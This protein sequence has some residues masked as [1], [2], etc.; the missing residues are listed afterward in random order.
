MPR[1]SVLPEHVASQIAAGEVVER[2]ASVVKELVEN[3][4]DAGATRMVIDVSEGCRRIRL[5]DNGCGMEADDATLAFQRHAT[6]KLSS[7]DD[8]WNL[9]TLGFRGEAL[10]SIAAV[11]QLTCYTRPANQEFGTK[12][13]C[14]DGTITV[15]ETGCAQ[16][17]IIEVDD[18][19]YNV[20]ARLKFLKKPATEF[21]YIYE[22]VQSLA[23]TYPSI[24]FQ[25]T[26]DGKTRL[27]TSGSGNFNT[28]LRESAFFLGEYT[29]DENNL[30]PLEARDGVQGME[31]T[32]RLASAIS[33]RG[34]R[35]GILTIVNGRPV[36]CGLT[37]KALDNAY[38]DL[39]PRGRYPL[40]VV[41]LKI[42]AADIDINIHPTKKEIRYS[43]GNDVYL[44]LQ[45]QIA[46]ALRIARN[47]H[48]QVTGSGLDF[49]PLETT[50]RS[51]LHTY[52]ESPTIAKTSISY[53]PE[54][55]T[56]LL[57]KEALPVAAQIESV[58]VNFVPTP[59]APINDAD[60]I[61]SSQLPLDWKIV[62]YIANTYILIESK[63]GLSIVEQHIAHER[64][65]YEKLLAQTEQ[66]TTSNYD[67]KQTLIISLP[68]NLTQEQ[69]SI[70]E[71]HLSELAE[72][73]FE[74]EIDATKITCSQVPI[75]LA[76]KDYAK[77]IQ[78]MLQ[79]LAESSSA[80]PKL[81]IIKSLA[82][83]S[84]IKNGMPL[85]QEQIIELLDTWYKTPRNETCPHGR[86][87]KLDFS[88]DKLFQ[89][90]HPA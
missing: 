65:L 82:C 81:D 51:E 20:P 77:I 4:I 10:P 66:T 41:H 1:I 50:Y 8:L 26:L 30:I 76:H 35:K 83:Q 12:V 62:G 71:E 5:A 25:L 19:F 84:A 11:S 15:T 6:S 37:H 75:E 56:Q 55:G 49:K 22:I 2:P 80:N 17:T 36:R 63:S 21:A 44:F 31:L 78:T 46:H 53:A 18:L 61:E 43:K 60:Q 39:I 33:F 68:L 88:H 23:I 7:A 70:L 13:F 34:D 40:A 86:P 48:S 54:I 14:A 69:K 52:D 27:T 47:I 9:G 89:L 42:S 28:T 59:T 57:L 58:L 87:I 74:F 64:A 24:A 3:A 85:A 73:G 45:R 67:Y 90:F 29:N 79:E 72:Q 32:G 38:A 16:G